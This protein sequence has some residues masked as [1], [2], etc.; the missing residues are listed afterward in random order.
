MTKEIEKEGETGLSPKLRFLIEVIRAKYR[1]CISQKGTA[2]KGRD[3]FAC[4]GWSLRRNNARNSF[5]ILL[6]LLGGDKAD[7]D[8]TMTMNNI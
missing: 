8:H 1:S 5:S 7:T 4:D 3:V 2:D 6:I